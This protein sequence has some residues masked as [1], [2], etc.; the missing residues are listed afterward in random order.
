MM[1]RKGSRPPTAR[2][3]P[4]FPSGWL[5]LGK[6]QESVGEAGSRQFDAIFTPADGDNFSRVTVPV[7]VTVKPKQLTPPEADDTAFTYNGT[8]HAYTLAASSL[9]TIKGDMV[10]TDAGNY[11]I[12]VSLNDPQNYAWTDGTTAD[13]AYTFTIAKKS[14]AGAEIVLGDG[15]T[16]NGTAQEQTVAEGGGRRPFCHLCHRR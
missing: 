6:P 2:H 4:T 5:G 14:I 7:S 9:Y 3:W 16:Y 15:L 10:Q 1:R 12:T 11:T 8:A 13:K